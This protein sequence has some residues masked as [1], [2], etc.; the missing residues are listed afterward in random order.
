MPA[1]ITPETVVARSAGVLAET[2]LGETVILDVAADRYARLNR[3]GDVLWKRLAE[4]ATV[5]ELA[6]VLVTRYRLAEDRA[7]RDATALVRQLADRGLVTV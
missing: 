4:P 7:L 3:A 6:A 1:E 5:A 2:V